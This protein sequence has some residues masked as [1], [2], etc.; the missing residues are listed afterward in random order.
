MPTARGLYRPGSVAP[1]YSLLLDAYHL[2]SL[3]QGFKCWFRVQNWSPP[4]LPKTTKIDKNQLKIGT[5]LNFKLVDD[6]NW[7]EAVKRSVLP[8]NW[9]VLPIYRY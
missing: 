4:V 2:Q 9:S 8:V 3:I 6:E 1:S 7:F 5:N